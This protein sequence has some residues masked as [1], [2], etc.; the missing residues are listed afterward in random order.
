MDS[1]AESQEE[2]KQAEED[3]SMEEG[4]PEKKSS[5][6][7]PKK[8]KK[9][10]KKLTMKKKSSKKIVE[11]ANGQELIVDEEEKNEGEKKKDE[12]KD[13]EK[14]KDKE[15]V[16]GSDNSD[17]EAEEDQPDERKGGKHDD[18]K[19]TDNVTR[20]FRAGLQFPVGRTE[21]FMRKK[22]S[23]MRIGKG[24]PVYMAAVLEYLTAEILELSGN[25]CR[26]EKRQR[27]TPT[28]IQ[29]AVSRD[30]ELC[31]LWG[32]SISKETRNLNPLT[33]YCY[34]AKGEV[35][36]PSRAKMTKQESE[37]KK[38]EIIS[39]M[40]QYDALNKQVKSKIT[41]SGLRGLRKKAKTQRTGNF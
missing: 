9:G 12:K 11:D 10:S 3:V 38:S 21:R 24:A 19:K 36:E 29:S 28:H 7:P 35:E 23:D 1:I 40:D 15:V 25:M 26:E 14:K 31:R 37:A 22:D 34:N 6:A 27:I 8:K 30:E 20:S 32:T 5:K 4:E 16:K 18:K 2:K 39:L 41:Y 33:S 17:Y 13:D